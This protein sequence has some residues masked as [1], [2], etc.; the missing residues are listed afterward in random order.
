MELRNVPMVSVSALT[1]QRVTR[2][3]D[4][5]ARIRELMESVVP[6]DAFRENVHEWVRLQ[7]HPVTAN[8]AVKIVSCDQLR[9][10]FPLFR[11]FATNAILARESYKR[12]L[13]NKI[14]E[15]YEFDGCPVVIEFKNISKKRK[16]A[17]Q[18]AA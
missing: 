18:A 16:A 1:G 4:E 8:K 15:T 7:P 11:F 10:R 17:V 6:L 12:Y 14:Y 5:A 2:V 13:A 3:I 9:G